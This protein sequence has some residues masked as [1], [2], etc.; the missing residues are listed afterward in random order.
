MVEKCTTFTEG[1]AAAG[2]SYIP[3]IGGVSESEWTSAVKWLRSL[4]P[5]E[6]QQLAGLLSR[7]AGADRS[8]LVSFLSI[9]EQV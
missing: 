3:S 6:K 8:L 1:L 2:V 7:L 5:D 9:K 4:N